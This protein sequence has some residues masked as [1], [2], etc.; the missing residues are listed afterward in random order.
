MTTSVLLIVA[1]RAAAMGCEVTAVS[2]DI[3]TGEL[4]VILH[5]KKDAAYDEA[6][7][8]VWSYTMPSGFYNANSGDEHL[9]A[10]KLNYP[11][12]MAVFN[13]REVQE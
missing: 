3:Y 11:D 7:Y 6:T 10:P 2:E 4:F 12:A 5:A 13:G 8:R 9:A 1:S